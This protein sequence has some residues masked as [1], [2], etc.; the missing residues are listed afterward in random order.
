MK[1]PRIGAVDDDG[2]LI[3]STMIPAV[4][5][6]ATIEYAFALVGEPTL[7]DDTGLEGF[8]NVKVGSLDVTPRARSGSVLP[9]FI[10]QLI[11][12]VRLGGSGVHVSR[13]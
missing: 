12:P 8:L 11:R 4:I 6:Q 1:W 2:R 13:A 10:K 5:Q 7:L 3:S 9:A